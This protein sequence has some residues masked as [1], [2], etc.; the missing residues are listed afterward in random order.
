MMDEKQNCQRVNTGPWV[1]YPPPNVQY[2]SAPTYQ[3]NS[4]NQMYASPPSYSDATNI[5]SQS[6]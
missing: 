6:G 1:N 4:M 5:Q 2:T 3:E